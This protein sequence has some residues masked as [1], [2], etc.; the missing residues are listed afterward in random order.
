MVTT[1]SSSSVVSSPA[2]QIR[3]SAFFLWNRLLRSTSA[4]GRIS[5]NLLREVTF[6]MTTLEYRRPTPLIF[7]N[8]NMILS[9]PSTFV[10]SRRRMCW[11]AFLSGTTRAMVNAQT[12]V[13]FKEQSHPVFRVVVNPKLVTNCG[14]SAEAG[15]AVD[16]TCNLAY[17]ELYPKPGRKE[18]L[19]NS[20]RMTAQDSIRGRC[21][22]ARIRF[23]ILIFV[24]FDLIACSLDQRLGQN[25]SKL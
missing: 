25:I 20:F 3:Y 15:C 4:Y 21:G 11:K 17:G 8:A 14:K 16:F 10:L 9:F 7:V 23:S 24:K 6:L 22:C 18:R 5:W 1:R 19:E 12:T 2:L 13:D